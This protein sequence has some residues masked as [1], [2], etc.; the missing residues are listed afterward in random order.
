MKNKVLTLAVIGF[1]AGIVFMGCQN[2]EEK[3]SQQPNE[4]MVET[5]PDSQAVQTSYS[6]EWQSFKSTSEQKIQDN[7]NSI[8][9]F[10]EKMKKSGTKVKA[11]YNIEI[12]KLEATNRAMKK[13]L[14]EYKNDGKSAWEDFK[15]GFNMDMDKL[16]KAVK[17]LT[18]DND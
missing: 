3:N 17:D 9:A 13:K 6:D 15:T 7:E 4:S 8:T 16:G 2:T 1:M 18:S 10:K 12:A 14:E 11:K 5:K